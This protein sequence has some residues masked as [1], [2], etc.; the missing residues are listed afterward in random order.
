MND[1]DNFEY[2]NEEEA[3]VAQIRSLQ[4]HMGA[5]SKVQEKL[6]EQRKFES[7]S[8]CAECGDEI[9]EARR[10]AIP[11]VMLCV[12]CQQ[13]EERYQKGLM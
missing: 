11:G 3:E 13:L 1:L 10:K 2:N 6:A 9:P 5:L 4:L 7:L 8:E 12:H